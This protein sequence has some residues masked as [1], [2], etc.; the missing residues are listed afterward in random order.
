MRELKAVTHREL[1]FSEQR[2]NDASDR[3]S[4]G[5]LASKLARCGGHGAKRT[6]EKLRERMG[7]PAGG[8]VQ[9]QCST[10]VCVP[11][12]LQ[13]QLIARSEICRRVCERRLERGGCECVVM[14]HDMRG[15]MHGWKRQRGA[16]H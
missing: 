16:I 5:V 3:A 2:I 12:Q 9:A 14:A 4:Y 13:P 1:G 8:E 6:K 15:A 10:T 7:R 11:S